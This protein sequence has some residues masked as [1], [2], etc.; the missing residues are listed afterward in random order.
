MGYE[1]TIRKIEGEDNYFRFPDIENGDQ[2]FYA[3]MGAQK[4][5][6]RFILKIAGMTMAPLECP[7]CG[8]E[9]LVS[10][11]Q[12]LEDPNGTQVFNRWQAVCEHCNLIS[13]YYKSQVDLYM[14]FS[15]WV[16][17]FK[18]SQIT[19]GTPTDADVP[20]T[21]TTGKVDE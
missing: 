13:D 9:M 21:D 17:K 12:E 10:D 6:E 18:E 20:P 15:E 4:A 5:L 19:E 11:R 3:M 1:L 16:K 14:N 7:R 2:R 8:Y